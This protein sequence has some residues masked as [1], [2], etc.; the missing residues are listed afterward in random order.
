M[1]EED[2][3]DTSKTSQHQAKNSSQSKTST[4]SKNSTH[5]KTS[6]HSKNTSDYKTNAKS[7]DLKDAA[8]VTKVDL[9]KMLYNQSKQLKKIVKG[10]KGWK[11]PVWV[12]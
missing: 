12:I 8:V 10:T 2:E 5:S 4:Q 9:E 1:F 6:I 11:I 3:Q 7:H